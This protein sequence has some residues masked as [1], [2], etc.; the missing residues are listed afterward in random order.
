M[1][2]DTPDGPEGEGSEQSPEQAIA[3]RL[4][5]L[6]IEDELRDSY[7]TYAM[8]VIVS[9]ALPDVRDG[10]K[11]SQRRIL[12]AMNDLGLSPT[13]PR[14]KCAKIAGETMGNYH[15]HG[16]EVIYPTLVR[17][18]QEW[19]T[20][21][22]LVDKQ[23]NFGSVAGLPPAAMR[24]TEARLSTVA[25][26]MLEDIKLDTVDF[27]PN[28]DESRSEPSVLP[29]K[30][31]NLLVNGSGGIAVGMATSIPPHNLGEV[32]RGL[33]ALIDNPELSIA[34]LMQY[35]PGPDFPTGGVICGRTGIMRGYHTGRSTVV[36]R[37]RTSIED[38]GKKTRIIVH[39][40]PYQQARDKVEERIAQLGAEGK[41]SG[42]SAVHNESDLAEP[43]RL[44]I[45]LKRDADP[46]VVLNQLYKFSPL[47]DSFSV[48][49]LALVDGKPRT[50]TLKEMLQEFLRHRVTVVRRRTQFLLARARKRKHT[51][52]GLLIAFADIDEVI[53]VIRSSKTQAEAKERLMGIKAPAA[54]LARALGP[55]GFEQF[56]K[57]R[58]VA[59]DYSL[60]PVQADA[61]LKMTL[62]QL[63]NLEQEKLAEEHATLLVEIGEY[64]VILADP[65]RIYA[66]IR[67]DLE[68]L[69]N[70]RHA[71]KRKTELSDEEIGDVDLEDLIEE[72]TM[73]VSISHQGYIK[74]TPAS[75]YRAQRR[76]GKGIKGA[77]ADED[78]PVEHLFVTSTHDYLLFFTNKGRV[79]WQKVYNLPALS[80]E[81]K[82]RAVVNLLNL[83]EGETIADC[84]A[85][86]DF[87]KP[88]H[89][90]MMA[91]RKGLVKKTD[92]A[93]YS[94]P[95]KT[96]IIAI[97][98]KEDDELVDVVITKPGDEIILATAGGMA[99]RFSEADARPMGRNTS[100]VKG[101][102]LS[103][104][105]SLVGMVVADPEATL[106]TACEKGYGKRTPFGPNAA[107]GEVGPAPEDGEAAS[108]AGEASTDAGGEGE[109]ESSSSFR[110]RTQN[111]GGKGLRDIKTT[112]RNGPVVSIVRVD[113]ADELLMMTAR[114]KIQRIK[115]SDVSVIGR[116][117]QGVR[118]MTLDEGDSLTAV[119][120]VPKDENGGADA[121]DLGGENGEGSDQPGVMES[122]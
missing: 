76:G 20:R 14:A 4:I 106:L 48:I 25:G 50:L 66:I 27:V 64:L 16:Q 37:A 56:Q 118:I 116:N 30:F 88:D 114:G 113:D 97:K 121:G 7:L 94:R 65:A 53:R 36:L 52:Q 110:Y 18:A 21:L 83:D 84:R 12:V 31:P 5:D 39:E 32:C 19:N 122:E 103:K 77:Q 46:D 15:P 45:D 34:E 111:R 60:T 85:V 62:G 23:G 81:S 87:D 54:M 70:S 67:E 108:A 35:I 96:G 95:M 98:L 117:T 17:M 61:I 72:E 10:L 80:R 24:Y 75:T 63:V 120:R 71:E 79:Y 115:A 22:P 6:P 104:G 13:S 105:D 49:L 89:C 99:I 102:S 107:A 43:V 73:V 26:L 90:L 119:V 11:P 91:T 57:E 51:I 74:R 112:E 33:I 68:Q 69:A 47:Q 2:T 82:G 9:R 8:S 92:L 1:S 55:E 40:I 101:V 59:E 44:I 29:S 28:Y 41:I 42:I 58:G 93:A 109:G 100:G 78:D 86:R 38:T 3:L